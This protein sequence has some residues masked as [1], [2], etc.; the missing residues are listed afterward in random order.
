MSESISQIIHKALVQ[1]GH[2]G[3]HDVAARQGFAKVASV[4]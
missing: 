1:Y 4:T 2:H 3:D